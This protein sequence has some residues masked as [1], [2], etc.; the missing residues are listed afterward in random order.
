[1]VSL[2]GNVNG[3]GPKVITLSDKES[4]MSSRKKWKCLHCGVD[5]GKIGEHYMLK[6]SVWKKVHD[7]STGMICIGCFERALGRELEPEDFNSSHINR[8]QPGKHFSTRLLSRLFVT[9]V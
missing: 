2:F 9:T 4:L 6:D 3:V 8:P 5:T 7:S 1:M